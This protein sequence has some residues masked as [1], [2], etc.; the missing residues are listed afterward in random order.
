[1]SELMVLGFDTE[2][3]A[4]SFGVKMTAVLG[5]YRAELSRPA[6]TGRRVDSTTGPRRVHE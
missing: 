2:A 1:M 3:E 4:D 6:G 5:R